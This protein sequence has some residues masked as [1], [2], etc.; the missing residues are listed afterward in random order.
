MVSNKRIIDDILTS[1]PMKARIVVTV[2]D[3]VQEVFILSLCFGEC[4]KVK[5]KYNS[6]VSMREKGTRTL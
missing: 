5:W 4:I 3:K 1:F 2:Q 6:L